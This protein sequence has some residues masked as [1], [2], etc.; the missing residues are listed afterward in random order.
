MTANLEPYQLAA[1]VATCRALERA[2]ASPSLGS[3]AHQARFSPF[4]LHRLFKTATGITPR[5]YHGACRAARVRHALRSSAHIP[6]V[7]HHSGFSSSGHFYTEV[8]RILGMTPSR[9]RSG[10]AGVRVRYATRASPLARV[11]VAVADRGVCAVL[12]GGR[13]DPAMVGRLRLTFALADIEPDAAVAAALDVAVGSILPLP[14]D[15]PRLPADIRDRAFG[16]LVR[17]S[18]SAVLPGHR[19]VP[20]SVDAL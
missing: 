17:S 15:L 12:L 20:S 5:S 3:L 8:S 11:L 18:V 9:Y 4:H 7:I 13:N 2:P 19:P 6:S 14:A 16:E 10:G 1:V